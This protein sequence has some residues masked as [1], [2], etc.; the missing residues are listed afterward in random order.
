M[1]EFLNIILSMPTVVYTVLMGIMAL[2]WV[3]VIMGAVDIDLFDLDADLDADM[4]LDLD[5]DV[6]VDVDVD[7]D[8]DLDVDVDTDVDVDGVQGSAGVIVSLLSA[9]GLIGIPL[10]ISLSIF[11]LFNWALT[12]LIAY[13]LGAATEPLS[14]LFGVGVMGASLVASTLLTS[15]AA[16]P[17]RPLF[18]SKA[19]AKAGR[20]L[21][22]MTVKVTS[23]S[24][25]DTFGRAEGTLEDATINFSIRCETENSLSKGD[26]ALVIG[27]DEDAHIYFVEPLDAMLSGKPRHER[28]ADELEAVFDELE[29]KQEEE[30]EARA[31]EEVDVGRS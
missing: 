8:T 10:T 29:A 23:G 6:D 7:L 3:T 2:Y 31:E 4:D 17:L 5:A 9:L 16:R 20:A 22:G 30:V 18:R 26:E 14:T 25:T 12:F 27:Y 21:V 1:Q 28:S 15:I 19:G 13:S 11:V 24:V